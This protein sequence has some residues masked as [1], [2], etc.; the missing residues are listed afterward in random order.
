MKR[1]FL[2]RIRL[3]ELSFLHYLLTSFLPYILQNNLSSILRVSN[4]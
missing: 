3:I 1:R 4:C 2:E